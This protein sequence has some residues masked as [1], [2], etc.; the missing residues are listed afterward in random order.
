M[1]RAVPLAFAVVLLVGCGQVIPVDP[2]AFPG[3]PLVLTFDGRGNPPV[4]L[5]I[6]EVDVAHVACLEGATTTFAPGTN[7]VPGLPW[8]LQVIQERDGKV[9]IDEQVVSMP[10]WLLLF[11]D[12]H[13]GIGSSP[14]LGPASPTCSPA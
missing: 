3:Q 9:L 12:G 4:I 11:A 8:H 14:A 10:K 2:S 13:G 6:N 7:G 5:R 1:A